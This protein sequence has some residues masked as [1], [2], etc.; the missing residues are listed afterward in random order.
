[1]RPQG[2]FERKLPE[3]R[4]RIL[5]E[6]TL[7]CLAREG[8]VGASIRKI[9]AE[10]G[11]SSG[12]INHHYPSKDNLIA[13]AYEHLSLSLLDHTRNLIEKAGPDPR[14][15]LSAFIEG[16][17]SA[18]TMDRGVLRTWVV[19]WGMIEES[20]PMIETH[21]RTYAQY[22][23]LLEQLIAELAAQQGWRGPPPRLA[24]IGLNAIL[25][26]LWLE[27]CLNPATFT[28]EEGVAL[29][30]GWVD[31]LIPAGDEN[32]PTRN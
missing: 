2:K 26:G 18:P 28:P 20:Q 6:A 5:I 13:D 19:F 22:R 32:S 1:M 17:L 31:G 14:S 4:R 23:N 8:H 27:W 10:A 15:R 3:D 9:S 7:A 29:C 30:E 11:I 25:D 21:D 24:A 12:L 16:S